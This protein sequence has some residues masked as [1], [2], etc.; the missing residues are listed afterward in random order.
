MWSFNYG[1][2][3]QTP[4]LLAYFTGLFH[5]WEGTAVGMGRKGKGEE[6]K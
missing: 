4:K 6:G 3:L 1:S 2:V 5:G